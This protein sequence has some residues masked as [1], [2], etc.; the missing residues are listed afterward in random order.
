MPSAAKIW[1]EDLGEGAGE[2]AQR[3]ITLLA[4]EMQLLWSDI[5]S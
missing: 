1:T 5:Y 2:S 3:G 4:E